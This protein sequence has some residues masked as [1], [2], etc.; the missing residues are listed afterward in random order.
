MPTPMPQGSHPELQRRLTYLSSGDRRKGAG[1]VGLATAAAGG[2]CRGP[3]EL[4]LLGYGF[5]ESHAAQ[6]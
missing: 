4:Q 5:N 3:N 1:M 6:C 2:S